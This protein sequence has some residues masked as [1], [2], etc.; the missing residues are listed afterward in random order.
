MPA[1]LVLGGPRSGRT[2]HAF[3]LLRGHDQV[4]YVLTGPGEARDLPPAWATVRTVELTRTLLS[5]RRPV[6]IDCLTGWVRSHL[7]SR[8]LWDDPVQARETIG[9]LLAELV[10]AARAVP[11]QVV[12]VGQ[13]LV[14]ASLPEDAHQRLLVELN[15]EVNTQLSAACSTLHVVLA[16]RVLDLSGAPVVR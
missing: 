6:I 7:D 15:A 13:E 1:T 16:G 4:T 12:L 14:A 9:P 5:A 2:R 10:V 3:S 8:A 11:N